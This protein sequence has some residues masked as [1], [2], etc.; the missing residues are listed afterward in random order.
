[1]EVS[2][3]EAPVSLAC[4]VGIPVYLDFITEVS[5]QGA[6]VSLACWVGIPV[7][8]DFIISFMRF[9]ED[10]RIGSLAILIAVP[11][12]FSH[13]RTSLAGMI[14]LVKVTFHLV[15]FTNLLLFSFYQ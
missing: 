15:T 13:S 7:Y 6:P 3:Q 10:E 5:V 14:V 11:V 12:V 8:L 1:T 2:V 9:H 4:W